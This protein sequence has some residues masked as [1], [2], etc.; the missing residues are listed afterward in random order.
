M[1]E[2]EKEQKETEGYT[3][4]WLN[5]RRQSKEEERDESKERRGRLGGECGGVKGCLKKVCCEERKEGFFLCVCVC[6]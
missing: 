5:W 1:G 2:R 3:N 6:V 4:E